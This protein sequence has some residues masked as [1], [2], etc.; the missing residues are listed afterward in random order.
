[1]IKK[2]TKKNVGKAEEKKKKEK[3]TGIKREN[4]EKNENKLLTL[5]SLHPTP[6]PTP[7]K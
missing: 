6:P 5:Y 2:M 1:M 4:E 7:Q 3:K